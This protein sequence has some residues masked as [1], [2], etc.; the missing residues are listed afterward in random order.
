MKKVLLLLFLGL[1]AL[2]YSQS[3][4]KSKIP[5]WSGNIKQQFD[6]VYIKSGKYQDY[7]VIKAF[8]F[9]KLKKHTLD[10]MLSLQ[11]NIVENKKEIEKLNSEIVALKSD[12]DKKTQT[13]K[14][15][16][17][18]KDNIELFGV[19]MNKTSYNILLWSIIGV[20]AFL[21]V[22]FIFRFINNNKVTKDTLESF[23]DLSDEYQAFRSRS[24]EREQ[25]LQRKLINEINKNN[26]S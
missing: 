17:G 7:K 11:K 3:P 21:L 8:W 15:L 2:S 16:E 25:A 10:S 14:G 24:L 26:A 22:F 19:Q 9:Q 23:K 5:D 18:Q 13:I 20:L 1:S 4:K 12:I 6:E